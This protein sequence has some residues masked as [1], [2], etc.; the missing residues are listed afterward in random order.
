MNNLKY[1]LKIALPLFL[2]CAVTVAALAGIN[3]LTKDKIAENAKE[4]LD[5]SMAEFFGNGCAVTEL[6]TSALGD[7]VKKAY[8]TE[9][10]GVLAGYAFDVT[11]SGAYKGKIE[12]LV[13]VDT[14][15]TVIGISNVSNGE[16]PSI[17]GKVLESAGETYK[18]HNASNVEKDKDIVFVS[19]ATKTSTALNNA[20]KNALAAYEKVKGS[21]AV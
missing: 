9:K 15:G 13:A 18:G 4:E 17:G 10:D 6:D 19:G 21:E 16:T 2:I 12:V 8:K 11:G 3:E 14:N 5:R 1:V 7:N 20:V